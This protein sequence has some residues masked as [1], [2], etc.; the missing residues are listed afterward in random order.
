MDTDEKTGNKKKI[1]ELTKRY[2]ETEFNDDESCVGYAV[3]VFQ[4]SIN[5][6]FR[7]YLVNYTYLTRVLENYGFV[8]ATAEDLQ[9]LHSGFTSAT[10]FFSDLFNKMNVE[11]KKNQQGQS[12]YESA[13][14]MTDGERTISFLNRYFIYKKVRKVSDAEKVSLNLQHK[15]VDQLR[16]E[17]EGSLTAKQSVTKAL[18]SAAVPS[19]AV[20]SSAKASASAA[21]PSAAVP[22]TTASAAVPSAAAPSKKVRPTLNLN[23]TKAKLSTIAESEKTVQA[24]EPVQEAVFAVSEPVQASE[25]VLAS[26]SVLAKSVTKLKRTLKVKN[27]DP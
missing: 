12:A 2:N 17:A 25:P 5:K 21:V 1:W 15:T 3:D 20:P 24:Q 10:G 4:E 18:A 14:S 23:K 8:L 26:E 6:T 7:E 22:S 19:A 27:K 9:K 13:S 11:V 16:D